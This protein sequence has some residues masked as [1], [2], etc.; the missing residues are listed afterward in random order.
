MV[1][2]HFLTMI[3]YFS[4]WFVF[5]IL[6]VNVQLDIASGFGVGRR[7]I[8]KHTTAMLKND[9]NEKDAISERRKIIFSILAPLSVIGTHQQVANAADD[10]LFKTNPLTNPLLEQ[11][12]ILEQ[13][14]ADN[15]KYGGELA[16]GSQKGRE[17]Y[18]K[19][20]VPILQIQKD[21]IKVNDLIVMKDGEG[22]QEAMKILNKSQFEKLQFKKI[23]NAFGRFL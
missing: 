16:P 13:A 4:V 18:A 3:S 1:A 7:T 23:F 22:L 11:I 20:L 8:N 10:R 9:T 2:I 12:R 5:G 14:E 15:I 6:C 19:L 17:A 21:L